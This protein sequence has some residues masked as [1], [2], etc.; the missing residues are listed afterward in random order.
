[1]LL[2]HFTTSISHHV[3]KYFSWLWGMASLILFFLLSFFFAIGLDEY[4]SHYGSLV[5]MS[6]VSWMGHCLS[7]RPAMGSI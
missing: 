7:S 4:L 1:M 3:E 2:D 6:Y 5:A